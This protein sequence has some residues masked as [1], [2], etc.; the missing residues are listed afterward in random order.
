MTVYAHFHHLKSAPCLEVYRS[1]GPA[2]HW[3]G[4]LCPEL[5]DLKLQDRHALRSNLSNKS[6]WGAL[7]AI[8]VIPL[9]VKWDYPSHESSC[10]ANPQFL[11]L[12]E[13]QT[14]I[15]TEVINILTTY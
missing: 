5:P 9:M 1:D 3:P 2:C 11:L 6:S 12:S 10:S 15:N 8:P 4:S 14:I 7:E 13:Q